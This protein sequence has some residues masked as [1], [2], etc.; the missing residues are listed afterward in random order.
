MRSLPGGITI[1]G[2]FMV[3]SADPFQ[4]STMNN[5]LR[6]LLTSIDLIVGK[7]SVTVRQQLTCERIA[8]HISNTNIK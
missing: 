2:V 1:L 4:N 8:L 5:R 6:K 3:S 7:S